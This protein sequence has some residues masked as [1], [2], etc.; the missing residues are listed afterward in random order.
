MDLAEGLS[1]TRALIQIPPDINALQRQHP[2][3]AMKWREATRH[4]FT[5]ALRRGFLVEDFLRQPRA[6]QPAGV[7]LLNRGRKM[8]DFA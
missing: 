8:E 1:G 6:D 7:Y 5:E 2:E 4:A 3:Q